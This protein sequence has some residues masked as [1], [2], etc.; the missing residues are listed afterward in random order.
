MSDLHAAL[1]AL[2]ERMVHDTYAEHCRERVPNTPAHGGGRCDKCET[3]AFLAEHPPADLPVATGDA[4]TEAPTS[5]ARTISDLIDST[6]PPDLDREAWAWRRVMKVAEE[7][8]EVNEAMLGWFGENPRKGHTHTSEDVRRELLDVALAALAA[9]AHLDRDSEPEDDLAAHAEWVLDRLSSAVG[10]QSA[11]RATSAAGSSPED[12]RPACDTCGDSGRVPHMSEGDPHGYV[13]R[14]DDGMI[15]CPDCGVTASPGDAGETPAHPKFE[16]LKVRHLE[17]PAIRAAYE[18]IKERRDAEDG[19]SAVNVMGTWLGLTDEEAAKVPSLQPSTAADEGD[20][21]TEA[22]TVEQERDH[23]RRIVTEAALESYTP[24]GAE[25]VASKL[26]EYFARAEAAE[27]EAA[28]LRE[29]VVAV[30]ALLAEAEKLTSERPN[31]DFDGNRFEIPIPQARLRAA[32]A[33]PASVLAR[34]YRVVT[35]PGREVGAGPWDTVEETRDTV[36]GWA[37]EGIATHVESR[38]VG[39]WVQHTEPEEARDDDDA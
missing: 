22:E 3:L 24:D 27:Q 30:A 12:A 10:A 38:W 20:R 28:A 11:E 5:V 37:K 36:L 13:E 33:D 8:G 2:A 15:P 35:A 26:V 14:D 34:Q 1:S 19:L 6:Y 23:L 21:L 25:I 7:V 18:Q 4:G 32:L 17:N 29:Q 9:C 31:Y 39:P 16:V